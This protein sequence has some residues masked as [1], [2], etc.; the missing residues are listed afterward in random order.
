MD[1]YVG[2]D[3]GATKILIGLVDS[4]G[5]VVFSKNYL[6]D[7]TSQEAVIHMLLH[8]IDDFMSLIDKKVTFIGAGIVGHID[9]QKGIWINSMNIPIQT[10]VRIVE[11][12]EDKYNIPS[13][14]DNDVHCATIAELVYGAGKDSHDFIYINVGTGISAGMVCN[15]RLVRGADNY[16]GEFGHTS[17]SMDG[18]T[19]SCGRIGCVETFASGRG[20]AAQKDLYPLCK[21]HIPQNSNSKRIFELARTGDPYATGLIHNATKA[22]GSGITNLINLL[23]PEEILLGGS[24]AKNEHDYVKMLWDYI[25]AN[26]LPTSLRSLRY[27]GL[28]KLDVGTI[29]VLGASS[30]WRV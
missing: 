21:N 22:L 11:M 17:V 1:Y 16:A 2:V 12:I 18:I 25:T 27:F 26:A 23:N 28:S 15:G 9:S 4:D 6:V 10:P 29:G 3:V 5:R 20:I 7:K 13:K 8:S 24:V 19:C 30:L 14:I